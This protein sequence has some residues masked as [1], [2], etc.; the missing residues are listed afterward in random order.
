MQTIYVSNHG[1]DKNDG[2][3]PETPVH[4]WRRLMTLCKG[5]AMRLKIIF[6]QL[7]DER[8]VGRP[9]PTIALDAADQHLAV[10]IDFR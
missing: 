4:S 1:D 9:A 5:Q 6:H 3:T 7:H 10:T 2:L 8:L